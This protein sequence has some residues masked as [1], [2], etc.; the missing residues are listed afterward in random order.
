MEVIDLKKVSY[1]SNAGG[2]FQGCFLLFG[3]EAQALFI[4][5]NDNQCHKVCCTEASIIIEFP[6]F[7][8]SGPNSLACAPF[9]RLQAQ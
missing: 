3:A 5:S 8:G 4:P 7:K 9:Y 2:D 1:T 6:T